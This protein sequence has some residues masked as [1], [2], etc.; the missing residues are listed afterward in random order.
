MD[1][2]RIMLE[3]SGEFY[4]FGAVIGADGKLKAVG[5][6]DGN[7]RPKSQDIYRLL[8]NAL[9]FDARAGNVLAVALAANV[10]IPTAYKPPSPDGLRVHLEA[11]GYS[12]LVYVPYTLAKGRMFKKTTIAKYD[13]PI[14][15]DVPA[16]LFP[17]P[18]A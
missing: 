16:K 2:G 11:E 18:K 12:R 15:V 8:F 9:A 3:D 13:E 14:S 4:P 17:R 7:E 6:Y 5:G 1:F 10:N